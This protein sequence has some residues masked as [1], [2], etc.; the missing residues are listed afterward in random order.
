MLSPRP[1]ARS[2]G[3]IVLDDIVTRDVRPASELVWTERLQEKSFP[4]ADN[5]TSI[6]QSVVR[7][8]TD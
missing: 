2:D 8:Y 6:V 4:S 5:R 7:H 1:C 3:V